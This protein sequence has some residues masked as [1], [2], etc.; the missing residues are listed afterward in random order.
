MPVS[1]AEPRK[2][3]RVLTPRPWSTT[4]TSSSPPAVTCCGL[5][6]S[7]LLRSPTPHGST[8]SAPAVGRAARS[9]SGLSIVTRRHRSA[10]W[11]SGCD[12]PGV[13]ARRRCR[14]QCIASVGGLLPEDPLHRRPAD[15]LAMSVAVRAPVR[16]LSKPGGPCRG[17]RIWS[18]VSADRPALLA[19]H[20]GPE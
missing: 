13:Q 5:R 16:L 2:R 11:C 14:G 6:R 9:I 15:A 17:Q 12:V 3:L 19:D 18:G 4:G 7:G 1:T 8:C 10:P 20:A